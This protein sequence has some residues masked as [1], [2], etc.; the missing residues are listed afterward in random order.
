MRKFVFIVT[1]PMYGENKFMGKLVSLFMDCEKMCGP[2]F[3]KGLAG[4]GKIVA[5]PASL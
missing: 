2:E 3:E 1:C 5:A 4:L